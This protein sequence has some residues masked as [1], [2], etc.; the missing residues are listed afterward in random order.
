VNVGPKEQRE[1]VYLRKNKWVTNDEEEGLSGKEKM[2][3]GKGEL[4]D[5]SESYERDSGEIKRKV[6]KRLG[7]NENKKF[8]RF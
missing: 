1:W 8:C 2:K 3:T 7:M 6:R 4:R 5:M